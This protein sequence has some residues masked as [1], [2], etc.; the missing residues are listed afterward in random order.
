MLLIESENWLL[1]SENKVL[2]GTVGEKLDFI[3]R[4]K[5]INR[6]NVPQNKSFYYFMKLWT[7]GNTIQG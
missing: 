5:K 7:W 1:C 6:E 3:E 2:I 4:Y